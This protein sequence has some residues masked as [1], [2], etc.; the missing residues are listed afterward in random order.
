MAHRRLVGRLVHRDA[1]DGLFDDLHPDLL[2]AGADGRQRGALYSGRAVADRRLLHRV[3]A[4]PGHRHPHD[5]ALCRPGRRRFRC[6]GGRGL[7]VADDL[8]LVRHRRHRLCP[9][10]DPAAARK[11]PR[12]A[13]TEGRRAQACRG[14]PS[15]GASR[16]SS[17]ISPSGRSSS[18]SPRR[19]CR[20]GRPRTGSRR[21][22][23][24]ASASRC[25]RPDRSRPSPSPFR[26]SWA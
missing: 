17:R 5:R 9:G 3:E 20:A 10:A 4:Q 13:R 26:R 11:T 21:S 23:P 24:R 7:L 12:E 25:R 19:R 15:G 1:A 18:T 6:D 2:A 16:C 14:G 8:P 22:S